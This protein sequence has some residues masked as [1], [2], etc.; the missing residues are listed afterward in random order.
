MGPSDAKPR[1]HHHHQ[2]YRFPLSPAPSASIPPRPNARPTEDASYVDKLSFGTSYRKPCTPRSINESKHSAG[3]SISDSDGHSTERSIAPSPSRKRPRRSAMRAITLPSA[4]S[5]PSASPSTL[6]PKPHQHMPRPSSMS[7][8]SSSSST[9]T[10]TNLTP[11][12]P[13]SAG[14]GRKVAASLQLFKETS[15][16]D[17]D[18]RT[19][20]SSDLSFAKNAPEAALSEA[21]AE[22]Q[23]EFVKRSEWPDRETAA[24][25]RQKSASMLDRMRPREMSKIEEEQ[26]K[27]KDKDKKYSGKDVTPWLDNRGRRRERTVDEPGQDLDTHSS[28]PASTNDGNAGI[29]SPSR[30]PKSRAHRPSSSHSPSPSNHLPLAAP[31]TSSPRSSFSSQASQKILPNIETTLKPSPPTTPFHTISSLTHSE[32]VSPLG[33]TVYSTDDDS[34]WDTASTTTTVSTTS[35]HLLHAIEEDFFAQG[36]NHPTRP[37]IYQRSGV[38]EGIET[39]ADDAYEQPF[40]FDAELPPGHL[41]HIPLRPFRNQVGGH[42]AIYKFTKQAVCKPLV[43]RENLFYEAVEREAPPLLSFIPRYLGVMLVTYRR[44][45]KSFMSANQITHRTSETSDYQPLPSMQHSDHPKM[46]SLPTES[47]SLTTRGDTDVDETEMPEVALE[48]NWHII[49]QWMLTGGRNRSLSSSNLNGSVLAHRRL[50][51]SHLGAASSP[52]LAVPSSSTPAQRKSPLSRHAPI[53]T[54]MPSFVTPATQPTRVHRPKIG[55]NSM[56]HAPILARSISDE[57]D[58]MNRPSF[59]SSKSDN[60][61]PCPQ[62]PWFGGTGSTTVNTRLKD[63]VFSTILRRFRR[64]THGRCMSVARADDEGHIADGEDDHVNYT[65]TVRSRGRRRR[66]SVCYAH[67]LHT[68]HS[69]SC[70]TPMRR[71]PSDSKHREDA[72][73]ILDTDFDAEETGVRKGQNALRVHSMSRSGSLDSQPS[74]QRSLSRRSMEQTILEHEGADATVTRQNHFILMEDLTGRLKHPCV[75]DLKMGT[76]QYGMDAT[77]AKKK[78]QRKKCERTTSRAL[79]VRVCGMQV[80]NNVTQTYVTQ[81]KY[82]GREVRKDDF[83]SVLSAFLFDGERLLAYQIPVLLEKLYALAR[84]I[85]RLKGYRFYGCSLLLIYDGDRESQ[86]AFRFSTLEHPSSRSKRGESLERRSAS[87]SKPERLR[88]SHSED[89]LV[90][91]VGKRPGG[92]RKRGEIIVRIVDFAHTTTGND[93]L[94]YPEKERDASSSDRGY[95]ADLDPETGLL[96]A[97]FPPH[98]PEQPDRG[99]LFGLKNLAENLEKIWNEERLRRMKASR[100][101]PSAQVYQLPPLSLDGKEIFN[102]LFGEDDHGMIST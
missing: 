58:S 77:L 86:E 84:I 39:N 88:R 33:S 62:S 69:D 31:S 78:S 36:Y 49:P 8:S 91:P 7:S 63:H 87:R 60:L 42:S 28:V 45:P 71:L 85:N 44:V 35:A 4:T 18:T 55:N 59:R 76:R 27:P 54:Q 96:Y 9:P 40:H 32:P 47:Q 73:G 48:R 30:R 17:D 3:G 38:E 5:P 75:L 24:T 89:L 12:P 51:Q 97:R 34:A 70:G 26:P 94:P 50:Q 61:L 6:T 41:P 64:R 2:H 98:H 102:D 93:W 52:D 43:S 92:R 56:S 74:L 53:G 82:K 20:E 99:F 90:G 67:R 16:R 14:I 57:D 68:A 65:R 19:D 100:D 22:A 46:V 72:D 23:F 79:G 25:R 11:H 10:S 95:Q 83:R 37:L 13:H 81:D 66:K 29:S 101:D 80:W 15:G 21:V 1:L